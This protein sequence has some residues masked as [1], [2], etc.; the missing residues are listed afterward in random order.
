MAPRTFYD[1]TALWWG[2]TEI[3]DRD[4]FRALHATL[5]ASTLRVLDLGA[6]FGGTAAAIAARGHDVVAVE[7]SAYRAALARR[8]RRN[9]RDGS[10]TVV[11]ADFLVWEPTAPFD[12]VTYWSGFGVGADVEHRR[13][14]ERVATWLLPEGRVLIDVFEPEWWRRHA[15]DCACYGTFR[16]RL[17]FDDAQCRLIDEWW[18]IDQ[19]SRAVRETIRCYSRQ[20]FIGVVAGSGLALCSTRPSIGVD[21]GLSYLAELAFAGLASS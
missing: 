10:L 15:G 9:V 14:L 19:P 12:V 21:L 5:G 7:S 8:H 20:E 6:G 2:T 1:R 13:L 18:R 17:G 16:Q 4:R 3:S 11:E